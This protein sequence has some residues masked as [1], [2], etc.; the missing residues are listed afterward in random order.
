[1]VGV[2]AQLP[3]RMWFA[4][5]DVRAVLTPLSP[6]LEF[7]IAFAVDVLVVMLVMPAL[8]LAAALKGRAT[9][10]TTDD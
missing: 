10:L 5:P 7:R 6:L 8:T 2:V 1:M 9:G 4:W 3:V